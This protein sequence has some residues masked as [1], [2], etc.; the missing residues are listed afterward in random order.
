M[1]R[2]LKGCKD[3]L[4]VSVSVLAYGSV[5][6]VLAARKGLSL[7]Q[8]AVMNTA[9]FAGTAQ[10]VMVEMWQDHLPLIEMTL[11]VLVM[12]LRYL[13]VGASL[14]SLFT[15]KTL[16]E[17]LVFMHLVTDESWAMT[18]A[19]QRRGEASVGHLFGGGVC[20]YLFW[21][22][23][24]LGGHAM[25]AAIA[26]PEAFALDFALIAVFLALVVGLWRGARS[27]LFPWIV[28]A[29]ASI[30]CAKLLPGKWYILA[31]GIC[32]SLAAVLTGGSAPLTDSDTQEAAHA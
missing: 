13:L 8:L 6:G 12:N 29:A 4:P 10:F 11:A 27:D 19:A 3:A 9:I 17:K 31:G 1:S 2:F 7:T 24:T 25:G 23:G 28:A 16:M 30:A 14:R 21:S 26:H 20:V 32:G 5:L 22:A 15:G 18:M